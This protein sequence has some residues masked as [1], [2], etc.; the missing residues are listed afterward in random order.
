VNRGRLV[1]LA[2]S[3]FQARTAA[4]A[5][6]MDGEAHFIA[7]RW[8]R[9]RRLL[10]PLRYLRDAIA[11]WA[12]LRRTNPAAVVVITPPVFAPLTAWLW[13]RIHGR[14]L[15]VDCHTLAL[16]SRRWAWALPLH[17]FLMRR[18]TIVLV[19]TDEAEAEL[20]GWGIPVL[21]VPDE[22]PDPL[23][24]PELP[25]TRCARVL[26]AGSL[27]W[28][29]PVAA[30]LQASRC[31]PD[32]EVR[33]SGDPARVVAELRHNASPNVVFTGWLDYATFLGEVRAAD[34]VAAFTGQPG[35][36]N[37]AA[38][39]A[40]ALS[41][42]LVLTDLP[43]MRERFGSAALFTSN[44]PD[45]IARTIRL[46]YEGRRQ[47][48]QKSQRLQADLR[49]ARAAAL[50]TLRGLLQPPVSPP[51]RRVLLV[52]QHPYPDAPLLRRNV[53]HLV[54]QGVQIDLICMKPVKAPAGAS[55]HGRLRIIAL[56]VVHRRGNWLDYVVEYASFLLLAFPI[57]VALGLRHR[58]D[59]VQIDNLPDY[60]PY[61]GIVPRLRGAR[62]VFYMYDM[63]PELAMTRFGLRSTNPL[64]RMARW[65]ERAA[66]R[67]VDHTVVVSD[68]FRRTLV[69]R[70]ID[71]SRVSVVYNTQPLTV[72]MR[73][74]AG[75]R[76]R[77]VTHATLVERY[78]VQ[79]AIRALPQL[80][81]AWPE[82]TYEVL[83]RG[84]YLPTL[85]RLA[86]ELGVADIVS[87][88]GFLPWEQAMDRIS[89]A[90]IGI[91]PVIADGFGQFILPMKLLEYVAM[92][93]PT[94]CARL[95][96]IQEH[97]DDQSLALYTPGDSDGLA[98]Q[99]DRLLGDPAAA[100]RQAAHALQAL[101]SL[102]WETVAPRYLA[103]LSPAG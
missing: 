56:P 74:P 36:M 48:A 71:P 92:G 76:P 23:L 77:L 20:R 82:L 51:I 93:I 99:V 75:P 100:E 103:A 3:S 68:L 9:S 30:V 17:R 88:V 78:G 81:R 98:R 43:G 21:V 25:R 70:G 13:S 6:D 102:R 42:P 37:R 97:F 14:P 26:V 69:S 52:S 24:A 41:K 15:V 60:L 11:T 86:A 44:E 72:A 65:L 22:L 59:T 50:A 94:V 73:Q 38:F 64:I 47:L 63:L 66:I 67:W 19:H 62:V 5:K 58:Y 83:G 8:L 45:A 95:P 7:G 28:D 80:R 2:W 27:D 40:V 54:V 89:S 79:V 18:S 10:L 39:E 53:E 35:V 84:E 12:D 1:A 87:F 91:V 16:H 4:L 34:V 85:E 90:T 46:A 33:L 55:H 31:L 57:V 29:E 96:G 101:E 49:A 32:M 61:V